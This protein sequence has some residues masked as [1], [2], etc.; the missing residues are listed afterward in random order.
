[1]GLVGHTLLSVGEMRGRVNAQSHG[2][3]SQLWQGLYGLCIHRMM[4]CSWDRSACDEDRQ[5]FLACFQ[6]NADEAS[7]RSSQY[8][9]ILSRGEESHDRDGSTKGPGG[10]VYS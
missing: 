8:I 10:W 1:M 6:G 5:V 7:G 3:L 9:Y 2:E 4:S